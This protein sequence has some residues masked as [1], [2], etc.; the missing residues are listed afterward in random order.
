MDHG[1]I[2]PMGFSPPKKEF[3]AWTW[4]TKEA[5]TRKQH[6]QEQNIDYK[7]HTPKR[8]VFVWQYLQK[9]CAILN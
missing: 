1:W 4:M 2:K 7:P 8:Q 6:A 3:H 9:P 5:L